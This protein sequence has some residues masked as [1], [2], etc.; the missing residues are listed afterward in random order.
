VVPK[1]P[2]TAPSTPQ[3]VA[4]VVVAGVGDSPKGEAAERVANGL[5]LWGGFPPPE[6]KDEW[7]RDDGEII[8][9]TP[10]RTTSPRGAAVDVVEFWWADLS[11]FPAALRSFLAAFI[12]LFLAFPAIGRTALRDGT[13]ITEE[14]QDTSQ[15]SRWSRLDFHLLGVLSWLIHGP[16]VALSAAILL[17]AGG[18][19]IALGL[20]D[21]SGLSAAALALYGAILA[22]VL[23]GLLRH[24]EQ[25]SGRRPVFAL[26]AASLL[27]A[28]G[29]CAW[30]LWE[31]GT[32]GGAIDLALGDT[33][34][35]LVAYPMRIVWL[36]VIAAAA[37]TTCLLA[38]R[39]LTR[40][41]ERRSRTLSALMTVGVGPLGI[42]TLMA[43]FSAAIGAA[44]QK[45]GKNVTWTGGK[46]PLCLVKP[47]NWGLD[48]CPDDRTAWDFGSTLLTNAI[49]PLAWASAVAAAVVAVLVVA[50]LLQ[51]VFRRRD[52]RVQAARLTRRLALLESSANVV[53][54]IT[55]TLT[56]A[57]F[58]AAAWLPGLPLPLGSRIKDIWGPPIAAILGGAVTTLLVAARV[59]GLSPTNLA[60]DGKAPGVLR[61]LL[62]KPYDIATFLREPLGYKGLGTAGTEMPRKKML[63]RF[64]K[65]M[66]HLAKDPYDRVVFV[67]HSQGTVLTTALLANRGPDQNPPLPK[68]VS[69]M[70]F[71]CP[72]Q[73][74]YLKRFPSQYAWVADLA[75]PAKRCNFVHRVNCE[76]TNVAAADD[77]I[78]RTVF[79][80]PP[81]PWICG[82]GPQLPKGTP[83]LSEILLGTGGHGSYWNAPPLFEKLA[84]LVD[85]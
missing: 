80:P 30:R 62:D 25:Q 49:Y 63:R 23:L 38:I 19:A 1:A 82:P 51:G 3:L 6:E 7:F 72:L 83:R 46:T 43:I 50:G 5:A 37:A 56:A 32:A 24:Y 4:V 85:A 34:T 79:M 27:A 21:G 44:G 18:L 35:V 48:H 77:P 17:T 22:F 9:V 69:L 8:R 52:A 20:R 45:V 81:E 59:M 36:A 65:L 70:T 16:V 14:P 40:W 53:L 78:G 73:Q 60:T 84:A 74:L 33:A 15:T 47:D 42:S 71:G 2:P 39:L 61:A 29:I 13:G 66:E 26:G 76:W 55:A 75:D 10:L 28:A 12:G 58:A 11:R 64:R 57:Y 31:R 54:L 67:A 41:D 68:S